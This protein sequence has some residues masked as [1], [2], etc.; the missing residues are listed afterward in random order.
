MY[1]FNYIHGVKI[2]IYLLENL[3]AFLLSTDF[4]VNFRDAL[5]GVIRVSISLDRDQA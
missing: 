2:S 5:R 4:K 3:H 1:M